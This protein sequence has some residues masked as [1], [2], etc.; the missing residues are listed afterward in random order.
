VQP[1]PPLVQL[2]AVTSHLSSVTGVGMFCPSS[3]EVSSVQGKTDGPDDVCLR[4]IKNLPVKIICFDCTG[5]VKACVCKEEEPDF[6]KSGIL[7][8]A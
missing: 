4:A 1:E 6:Q 5:A 8:N 7:Q 2:E 3:T